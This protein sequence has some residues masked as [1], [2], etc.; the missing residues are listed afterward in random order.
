[1]TKVNFSNRSDFFSDKILEP[2]VH[3]RNNKECYLCLVSKQLRIKT[4]EETIRQKVLQYLCDDLL[5]PLEAM[6]V[7]VP[8]SRYIIGS[9]D[10][11]DIVIYAADDI[12]LAVIEC[13]S[14]DVVIIENTFEQVD[15]YA[16]ALGCLIIGVTNGDRLFFKLLKQGEEYYRL[17]NGTPTYKEMCES[18]NLITIMP[19][20]QKKRPYSFDELH[21]DK[22]YNDAIDKG[23]LSRNTPNAPHIL[24]MISCLLL[25]IDEECENLNVNGY[26]FVKDL[27]IKITSFGN[28]SGGSYAG[29]YRRFMFRD[30]SGNTLIISISIFPTEREYT[31]FIVA[32]EDF[33]KQHNSL[34]MQLDKSLN[35]S[36]STVKITHTGRIAIGNIGSAKSN[37]VIE[38]VR[39]RNSSLIKNGKV[40]LGELDSTKIFSINSLDFRA[41][42]E[43]VISYALIRDEFREYYKTIKNIS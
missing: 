2:S 19:E 24:N 4:P 10:R 26:D 7:E 14:P 43:N 37:D 40:L 29:D 35:L 15:K 36:G 20:L 1:M 5:V 42:L 27:G 21:D 33:D 31:S 12:P 22:I 25:A 3:I 30:K 6:K 34:Q 8:M 9:R 13:K 39:E 23:Y 28:A 16:D 41:F 18:E 11:A 38:F 32:I 17:I